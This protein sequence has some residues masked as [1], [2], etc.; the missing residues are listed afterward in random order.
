ML[1]M[2]SELKWGVS[3]IAEITWPLECMWHCY[4]LSTTKR[5]H[6]T[7]RHAERHYGPGERADSGAYHF[8]EKVGGMFI[9]ADDALP[10]LVSPQAVGEGPQLPLHLWPWIHGGKQLPERQPVGQ[11]SEII[12]KLLCWELNG[13]FS[14]KI[15]HSHPLRFS[16]Y[17]CVI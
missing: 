13:G 17:V 3:V 6:K 4:L 10:Q 11:T 9:E 7:V 5:D 16:W 15:L 2:C 8:G 12:Q 1:V 14:L